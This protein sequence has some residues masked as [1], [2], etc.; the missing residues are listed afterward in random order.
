MPPALSRRLV[1]TLAAAGAALSA[2]AEEVSLEQT[3][4]QI[5][6]RTGGRLGVLIRDTG[7]AR[8]WAWRGTERFALCS[9]VKAFI[10]AAVLA[11]VEAGQDRLD[12]VVRIDKADLAPHSPVTAAH[13]GAGLSVAELCAAACGA[14]D[15]TAANLLIDR[16]GGPK[17][18]TAYMRTLGDTATR[19]DR[20]EPAL[21]EATPGDPRDTTTPEAA[22]ASLARLLLGGALSAPSRQQLTRWMEGNEVAGALLRAALPASWR[23]ADRSGAGGFGTRGII[24][25]IWPPGRAPV[26]AAVYL[27]QTTL[28][29]EARD[30]AIAAVGRALVAKLA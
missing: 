18:L 30:A 5:E 14:S 12:A 29:M 10:C 11:R 22:A 15:N 21:N 27:T 17:A 24:A 25:V 20:R 2:R 7:G 16:I 3:F 1:L 8:Q 26:V 4:Q 23:I 13:A 19:L 9:T 28:A 6:Q